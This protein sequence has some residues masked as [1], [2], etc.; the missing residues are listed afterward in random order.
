MTLATDF[1]KK[2]YEIQN[3][4]KEKK[5][6]K[7]HEMAETHAQTGLQRANRS[8]KRSPG[9]R[10]RRFVYMIKYD[11]KKSYK[12]KFVQSMIKYDGFIPQF[13]DKV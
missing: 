4:G 1:E 6:Q 9:V 10:F 5:R 11:I 3:L 2:K 12:A 7:I 13:Y 8:L